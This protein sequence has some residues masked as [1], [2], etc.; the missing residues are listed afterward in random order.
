MDKTFARWQEVFEQIQEIEGLDSRSLFEQAEPCFYQKWYQ[1]SKEVAEDEPAL[2][3]IGGSR[4]GGLPDLPETLSWPVHEGQ[5]MAFLAQVNCGELEPNFVPYLPDQGWLYFFVSA[6][7]VWHGIPHQILYF[8][9]SVDALRQTSLPRDAKT[10]FAIFK[11]HPYRFEAG[12]SLYSTVFDETFEKRRIDGLIVDNMF[13]K[14]VDLFQA[15]RDRIGGFPMSFQPFSEFFAYLAL[16]GFDLMCKYGT[17]EQYLEYQIERKKLEETDPEHVKFLRTEV[18][19]QIRE[20]EKD[21]DHHRAR[22]KDLRTLLVLGSGGDE[23]QWG[24]LGFLQFFI[25]KE[26]L[27]KRVFSRT[28]CDLIS[29]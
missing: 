11:S 3:Q 2:V 17:S 5:A 20:Y 10:P 18:Y 25:F 21:R 24:D 29:T 23:M 14:T 19:S 8:D 4:I 6:P 12:F 22:M 1:A 28:Q 15:E 27:E 16:N 9:G 26:D 7:N 13:S